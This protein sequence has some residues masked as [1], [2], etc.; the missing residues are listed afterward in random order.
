MGSP[1]PWLD[2]S[3]DFQ[4]PLPETTSEEGIIAMG[5]NLSPGMLLSAYRRGIFPWFSPGDPILWWC[6]DPRFVLFPG[7][8][9]VSKS[10]RRF[11]KETHLSVTLDTDFSG[12]IKGCSEAPRPAQDGTWISKEMEKGYKELHNLG[13]A[14][15]VE[16]RDGN[17]LAGGLYGVS[18]GKCFFGESMFAKK[19]N[20]SKFGFILFINALKAR[21]FSLID[22]QVYTPHLETLGARLIPREEFLPL[23]EKNLS[24]PTLRGKWTEEIPL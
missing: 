22:C 15:S 2:E 23:L 12:V 20:A 11:L 24:F 3:D 17:E 5:G 9:H 1:F 14:H 8:L 4:F 18:L 13:F 10:M 21:G 7:E 16:I 19:P 6:P